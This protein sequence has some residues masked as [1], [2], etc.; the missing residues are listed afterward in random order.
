[1]EDRRYSLTILDL[2]IRWRR[3]PRI[4][5]ICNLRKKTEEC[6]RKSSE[7][8]ALMTGE[9]P[10]STSSTHDCFLPDPL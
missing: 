6:Q 10:N 3:R 8:V 5:Y 7:Y 2:D 4:K 9:C 1:M